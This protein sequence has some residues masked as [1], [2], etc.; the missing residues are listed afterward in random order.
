MYMVLRNPYT[1]PLVSSPSGESFKTIFKKAYNENTR[2]SK[3]VPVEKVNRYAEIQSYLNQSAID[4]CCK[5][6]IMGDTNV[7]VRNN[8]MYC[9]ISTIPGDFNS[10][11]KTFN[12]VERAFNNLPR[13]VIGES[14]NIKSFLKTISCESGLKELN[15][16]MSAYINSKKPSISEGGEN[17]GE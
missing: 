7:T 4:L 15:A 14:T 13:E 6:L 11:Y 3:L 9:D 16:R 17:D 10:C 5:R 2:H 12:D 1:A 8:G